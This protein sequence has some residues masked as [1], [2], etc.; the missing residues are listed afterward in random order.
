MIELLLMQGAN[1]NHVTEK[2]DN[3]MGTY[4]Y[5]S[6][7]HNPDFVKALLRFGFDTNLLSSSD[8]EKI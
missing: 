2:K 7:P 5:W 3:I 6:D 1:I 4:L 8:Y